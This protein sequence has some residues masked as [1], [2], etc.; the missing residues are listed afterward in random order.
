MASGDPLAG[1]QGALEMPVSSAQQSRV[2]TA[3]PS[4]GAP[5]LL[6]QPLGMHSGP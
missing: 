6:G 3:R 5:V 2:G 1:V 4:A